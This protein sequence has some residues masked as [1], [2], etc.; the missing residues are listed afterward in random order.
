MI[1]EDN[2]LFVNGKRGE[3]SGF[4]Q[5]MSKKGLYRGY[6]VTSLWNRG[7]HQEFSKRFMHSLD[8]L[9]QPEDGSPGVVLPDG[10]FVALGDNSFESS[11]SRMWGGVP[12]KNLVGRAM[13]VYWPFGP[14]WGGID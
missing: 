12:K 14:H 7:I 5:V 9:K 6:E 3:E 2:E 11:D 1:T 10:V 8:R 4:K 13:I